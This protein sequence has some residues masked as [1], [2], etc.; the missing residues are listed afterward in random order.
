MKVVHSKGMVQFSTVQSC[1][2]PGNFI[3]GGGGVL[4]SLA[5]A[6]PIPG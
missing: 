6:K 2:D 5:I 3:R 1:A 4:H